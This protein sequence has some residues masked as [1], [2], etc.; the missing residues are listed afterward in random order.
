M[1]LAV[2]EDKA[3]DPMT[4]VVFGAE[5]EMAQARGSSHLVEEFRFIHDR[6]GRRSIK[7]SVVGAELYTDLEVL[8]RALR[9]LSLYY[10]VLPQSAAFAAL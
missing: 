1:A 8:D 5:T 9:L 10:G 2:K 7:L 4:I 6:E 3:S